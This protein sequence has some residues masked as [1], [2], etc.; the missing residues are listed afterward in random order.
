MSIIKKKFQMFCVNAITFIATLL[1]LFLVVYG[2]LMG[3]DLISQ[4]LEFSTAIFKFQVNGDWLVLGIM[5]LSLIIGALLIYTTYR[6]KE[7]TMYRFLQRNTG[8]TL[9]TATMLLIFNQIVLSLTQQHFTAS[10]IRKIAWW[11]N[12]CYFV[13][14]AGILL[15]LGISFWLCRSWIKKNNWYI[16]WTFLGPAIYLQQVVNQNMSFIKF[17]SEKTVSYSK[18]ALMFRQASASG[19]PIDVSMMNGSYIPA[20]KTM[21]LGLVIILMIGGVH[22]VLQTRQKAV[23]KIREKAKA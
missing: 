5:I 15:L 2:A 19:T 7:I 11:S 13:S 12:A 1:V 6:N 23:K 9:I 14:Y 10:S 21:I 22:F 20:A 4:Y 17:L 8:L 3:I 18:L 16:F